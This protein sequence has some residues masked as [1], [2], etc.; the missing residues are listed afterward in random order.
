MVIRVD[1]VGDFLDR[2]VQAF[3]GEHQTDRKRLEHPFGGRNVKVKPRNYH[4][5]PNRKLHHDA[6]FGRDE[7]DGAFEREAH[8]FPSSGKKCIVFF[9][10]HFV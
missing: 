6:V 9:E 10:F 1:E 4:R 5:D 2:S 7:L 3:N 8:A